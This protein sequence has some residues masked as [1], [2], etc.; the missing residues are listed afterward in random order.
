MKRII[1]ET[2]RNSIINIAVLLTLMLGIENILYEY[3]YRI[4]VISYISKYFYFFSPETLVLHR[5]ISVITGF[6]LI[7]T[8]YRL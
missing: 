8:S 3:Y 7:F 1:N 5:T 6:V 2:I 4:H